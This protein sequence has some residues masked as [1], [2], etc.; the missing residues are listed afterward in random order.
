MILFKLSRWDSKIQEEILSLFCWKNRNFL[1]NLFKLTTQVWTWQ[2][3]SSTV[4]KIF[5][6]ELT[7][8]FL[9]EIA[10]YTIVIISQKLTIDIT[11]ESRWNH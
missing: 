6:L 2:K 9:E 5:L 10:L 3:S 1:K 7:F 4:L 11:W 8:K